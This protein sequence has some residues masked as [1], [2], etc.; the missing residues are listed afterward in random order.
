MNE[1]SQYVFMLAASI[2]LTF[3][4]GR[5]LRTAGRPFLDEVFADPA[6]AE[7]VNRLLAVLFHLVTLGVLALIARVD[8]GG[9]GV[10][11]SLVTRLGV[12]LL[13]LGLAHGISMLVLLR[14]RDRRRALTAFESAGRAAR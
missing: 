3:M 12:V 14:V 13:V 1:T 8:V 9:G 10:L 4:V 6:V 7:S 5:V 11:Q 2:G